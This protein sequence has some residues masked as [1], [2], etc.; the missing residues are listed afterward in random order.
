MAKAPNRL[1]LFRAIWTFS[2]LAIILTGVTF[3]ALQSQ[4]ASLTGNTIES[5]TADLR[6]G[7]ST[8]SFANTRVG[9]DFNG[10]VPGGAA[11]PSN[12]NTFYLKNYGS[13]TLAIKVGIATAPS[14]INNVD[15]SKV[16]MIF[17]RV[18]TG[19]S[20]TLSIKS[21]V[22][23]YASGGVSLGDTIAGGAIAT[24]TV[25]VSMASDAFNAAS[26]NISGVDLSFTGT[27]I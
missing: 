7:T 25:K 15:L 12:G 16:S 17:T 10:V 8:S 6:I 20:T 23:G 13:G 1:P 26:A 22:D 2:A 19:Y 11:V 4:T 27:G 14:N 3:A 21:M 5:A 9:F 24:Y 18:D